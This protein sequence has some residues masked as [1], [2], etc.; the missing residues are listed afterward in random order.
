MA[1]KMEGSESSKDSRVSPRGVPTAN[2]TKQNGVQS[3]VSA[4][5]LGASYALAAQVS[6]EELKMKKEATRDHNQ[7]Q[8]ITKESSASSSALKKVSLNVGLFQPKQ[9]KEN[10]AGAQNPG[11]S[12][13]YYFGQVHATQPN[14]STKTGNSAQSSSS[15]GSSNANS[16]HGMTQTGTKEGATGLANGTLG[17]SS[18]RKQQGTINVALNTGHGTDTKSPRGVQNNLLSSNLFSRI[19]NG[20]QL[21]PKKREMILEQLSA[22]KGTRLLPFAPKNTAAGTQNKGLHV[23]KN[24]GGPSYLTKHAHKS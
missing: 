19:S 18:Q 4:N 7:H 1:E 21:D 11:A 5:G 24:E 3:S 8:A 6:Q 12:P 13:G 10:V 9:L 17:I 2:L 14:Q 22:A 15:G 20:K 23:G 16:T